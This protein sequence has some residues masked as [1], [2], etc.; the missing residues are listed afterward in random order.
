MLEQTA[1]LVVDSGY[2]ALCAEHEFLEAGITNR[3]RGGRLLRAIWKAH[4]NSDVVLVQNARGHVVGIVATP[5][6]GDGAYLLR[7]G[8]Q[9]L[10]IE[11]EE[12]T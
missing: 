12:S 11:L 7:Y 10:R 5:P 6:L 3:A 8:S 1:E 4:P 2:V 9:S